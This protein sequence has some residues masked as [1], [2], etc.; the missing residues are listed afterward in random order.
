[1]A[2]KI[3]HKSLLPHINAVRN[4]SESLP[5]LE[6]V[7]LLAHAQIEKSV[8][9]VEV[10]GYLAFVNNGHSVFVNNATL[11]RAEKRVKDTDILNLQFTS[12]EFL[13]RIKV[14]GD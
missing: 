9:G 13:S 3:G 10:M 7:V 6:R 2:T 11:R 1:M 14:L 5:E 4:N 8:G 12:G